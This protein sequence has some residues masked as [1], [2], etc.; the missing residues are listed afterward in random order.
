MTTHHHF[1]SALPCEGAAARKNP[2]PVWMVLQRTGKQIQK[3]QNPHSNNQLLFFL[4]VLG[5]ELRATA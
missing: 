5:F 1:N 4:V 2:A 3:G